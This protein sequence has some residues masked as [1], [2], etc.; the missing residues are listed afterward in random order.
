M[1]RTAGGRVLVGL[2]CDRA[3]VEAALVGRERA[4]ASLGR[5][6]E[7]SLEPTASLAAAH[8]G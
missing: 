5:V 3:S 7:G 1:A 2:A 8:A 4:G 6:G